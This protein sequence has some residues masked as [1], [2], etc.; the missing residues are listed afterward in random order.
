MREVLEY[1]ISK[2]ILVEEPSTGKIVLGQYGYVHLGR[3]APKSEKVSKQQ[4]AVKSS[5]A[6]SKSKDYPMGTS[7]LALHI[8]AIFP[9][10]VK[11]G[12]I[13]VRSAATSIEHKLKQ[14]RKLYPLYTEEQI[15]IATRKYVASFNEK[16]QFMRT[17]EYY[18]LKD[19]TSTLASFIDNMDEDQEERDAQQTRG[20][21][22]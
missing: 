1:L 10:G 5:V 7:K 19:G 18:I 6:K 12:N 4:V 14:F 16:Y 15:I 3:V 13:Y 22:V 17:A 20:E 11:S 9:P 2:D 8:R 21:M